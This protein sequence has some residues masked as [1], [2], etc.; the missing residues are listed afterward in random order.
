MF[1]LA[2][3]NANPSSSLVLIKAGMI[4]EEG[5][6][7]PESFKSAHQTVLNEF[8]LDGVSVVPTLDKMK[9]IFLF[10]RMENRDFF[11]DVCFLNPFAMVS[12]LR[13][14]KIYADARLNGEKSIESYS[15]SGH[16][17]YANWAEIGGEG[18]VEEGLKDT[19]RRFCLAMDELDSFEDMLNRSAEES[20]SL[21][22]AELENLV[23][24]LDIK[25][26][27]MVA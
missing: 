25:S 24:N 26:N 13:L 7:T 6:S 20:V 22:T 11:H 15:V 1:N 2:N 14:L 5:V 19:Y 10:S 9:Q 21:V 3:L 12:P 18:R 4:L 17:R 16:W 8:I 23:S 27:E